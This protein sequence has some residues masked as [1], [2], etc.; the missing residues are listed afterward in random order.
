MPLVRGRR[1]G[2][3][4]GRRGQLSALADEHGGDVEAGDRWRPLEEHTPQTVAEAG[5][6]LDPVPTQRWR[7]LLLAAVVI[8]VAVASVV[9]LRPDGESSSV[10]DVDLGACVT[11][12]VTDVDAP[13]DEAPC[14]A[15][16]A[17][18]IARVEHPAA[19][20]ELHPGDGAL[21]LFGQGACQGRVDAL[22]LV[23]AVPSPTS[24]AAGERAVACL[25]RL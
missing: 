22:A 12:V 13:V 6:E 8:G 5:L 20:D 24:W 11:P 25:E 18:L 21:E 7:L 1:Q 23:I 9:A 3:G 10:L 14:E 15:G 2:R 4:A 19:E 16:A 17:R